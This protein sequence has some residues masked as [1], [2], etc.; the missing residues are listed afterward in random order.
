MKIVTGS[1]SHTSNGYCT[2][3]TSSAPSRNIGD[4]LHAMV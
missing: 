2:Q 1:E 4:L 3:Q